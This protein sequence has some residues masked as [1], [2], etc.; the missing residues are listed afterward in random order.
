MASIADARFRPATEID[1][2][3]LVRMESRFYA[4]EGYPFDSI[5]ARELLT[6]LLH[7][8]QRGRVWVAAAGDR[9]VG[10]LILTFGFKDHDRY[11]MTKIL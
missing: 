2:D 10:Y 3:G 11:L 8:P 1:I 7:E 9:L 5:E 4:D 6:R